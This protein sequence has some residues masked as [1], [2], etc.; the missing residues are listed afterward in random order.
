M[1]PMV[2]ISKLVEFV[3]GDTDELEDLELVGETG[4]LGVELSLLG[5]GGIGRLEGLGG[6]SGSSGG[7]NL[8]WLVLLIAREVLT[9][10]LHFSD[11]LVRSGLNTSVKNIHKKV[12]LDSRDTNLDGHPSGVVS[13]RE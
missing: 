10:Q 4:R 11:K 5:L 1:E 9:E 6:G 7:L 13:N 8:L 12:L 2:R 3:T